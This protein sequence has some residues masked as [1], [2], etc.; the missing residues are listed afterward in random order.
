[1]CEKCVEIDQKIDHYR[2]LAARILDQ[3]TIY[4]V[5]KLIAELQAQ[6]AALHPEQSV[7]H[8]TT[9]VASIGDENARCAPAF[10]RNGAAPC[11]DAVSNMMSHSI[12]A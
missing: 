4:G 2:T 5:Q 8:R 6:K 7:N 3:A 11:S 12:S 9:P 10:L 1:M